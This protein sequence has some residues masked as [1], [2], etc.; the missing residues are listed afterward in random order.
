MSNFSSILKKKKL[1]SKIYV[2]IRKC[3]ETSAATQNEAE[4]K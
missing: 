2:N 1:F 4:R 3:V